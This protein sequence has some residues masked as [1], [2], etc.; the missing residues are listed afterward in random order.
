MRGPG[1]FVLSGEFLYVYDVFARRIIEFELVD[2]LFTDEKQPRVAA[3]NEVGRFLD[4]VGAEKLGVGQTL[5]GAADNLG[6]VRAFGLKSDGGLP[7]LVPKDP[8]RETNKIIDSTPVRIRVATTDSGEMVLYVPGGEAN[9]IHA[10]R[11]DGQLF[12][13]TKDFS[14]TEKRKGTFPNDAAVAQIAGTCP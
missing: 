7:T 14:A 4:L 5:F 8:Q 2:G 11:I 12:P 1:P 13:E 3:S 10:Y 9:K 6:R